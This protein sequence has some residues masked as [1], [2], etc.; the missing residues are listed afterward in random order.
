MQKV[1]VGGFECMSRLRSVRP[2]NSWGRG[3]DLASPPP[4][5]D[6]CM[7]FIDAP[8]LKQ[9]RPCVISIIHW[10]AG[11]RAGR[12]A[13]SPDDPEWGPD[14]VSVS[15]VLASPP[16]ST[17][18]P[19]YRPVGDPVHPS[20]RTVSPACQP[21]VAAQSASTNYRQLVASSLPGNTDANIGL[22]GV[23]VLPLRPSK[24]DQPCATL[25]R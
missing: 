16:T 18:G 1:L 15:G 25:S 10:P 21:T 3:I 14:E 23:A 4:A 17:I 24:I 22:G 9:V 5:G 2:R 6:V 12:A 13:L 20:L 11:W 8:G 7:H 19:S